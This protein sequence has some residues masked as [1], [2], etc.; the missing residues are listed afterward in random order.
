[1]PP[2][3]LVDS[4]T[5]DTNLDYFD[6]VI[7]EL[8]PDTDYAMQFAWVYEDKTLSPY[9]AS[10]DIHTDSI[11]IPEVSNITTSWSNNDLTINWNRPEETVNGTV[12]GLADSYILTLTYG[13]T[14]KPIPVNANPN[15]TAQQYILTQDKAR[16]FF[17]PDFPNSYTGLLQVVN[18][19]G[20]STGVSFTTA[21]LSD[22]I[23]DQDIPD[24]AWALTK[25]LDGYIVS[26][27]QFTDVGARA[28]YDYTEVWQS[29]AQTGTYTL[30]A[31][32]QSPLPVVYY[33][34][35]GT[36]YVKIRHKTKRNTYSHYSNV[37]QI[38]AADP[39]GYDATAPTNTS[40]ISAGTPTVDS[41]GLFDFNYK[42]PFSWNANADTTTLGYKIRWRIYGSS[43]AY[44]YMSVPGR[45]TASANLFG[46]LAGQ[47]Y[48]VGLS[49]YDEYDNVSSTWSTTTVA[50]PAFDGSI[51]DTK[52]IKA[53]DMKLGYGIGPGGES[54]NKGL[55]LSTNNYWYIYGNTVT[56]NTARI[57]VGSSTDYLSWDGSSM[58]V[59][60]TINAN[61]GNFTGSVSVGGIKSDGTSVP[62]QLRVIQKWD[63]TVTTPV[64]TIGLEIGKLNQT[65]VTVPSATL[66][67]GLYAYNKETSKYV[68]ID[69]ADGSIRANNAYIDGT[70]TTS[71]TPGS[72][73]S[74]KLTISGGKIS[75][76]TVVYLNSP[77][78]DLVTNPA[79]GGDGIININTD[80]VEVVATNIKHTGTTK[81]YGRPYVDQDSDIGVGST[82]ALRNIYILSTL[83]GTTSSTG[84]IGDIWIQYA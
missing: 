73:A 61:G 75:A 7:T 8:I 40:T 58:V 38:K 72:Y 70:I 28:I 53:G 74:N 32:G 69:A 11:T 15:Q 31:S 10:L 66:T 36:K 1:M 71:G 29:T 42:I 51:K 55:Y 35:L 18:S 12:V 68:L 47:T 84:N 9:S 33:S 80:T 16:G 26:W 23:T 82:K 14:T 76:D 22:G 2:D 50:V 41:N 30:V 27:A 17:K 43:D 60:G 5:P 57:K 81:F 67:S 21:S 62:G 19:D 79:V 83:V 24:S 56:D 37:K 52:Y 77:Y 59:T 78:I 25:V 46:V 44:V 48:E 39:S 49:V 64:P 45:T 54:N 20:K 65:Y 13:S 3:L 63:T 4:S 34:D 6:I